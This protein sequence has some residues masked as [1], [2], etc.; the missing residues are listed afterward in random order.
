MEHFRSLP[1]PSKTPDPLD[2]INALRDKLSVALGTYARNA[3]VAGFKSIVCY[4]TGLDI[5]P[6]VNLDSDAIAEAG[7]ALFK[8]FTETGKVRLAHKPIN[9][10]VV[11]MTLRIAAE[12]D[13][14]GEHGEV[15]TDFYH[16]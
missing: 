2:V 10:L 7:D 11:G 13:K 1:L 12:F 15:Q 8:T 6:A 4:R 14:P 5:V 9:D 16:K 3:D